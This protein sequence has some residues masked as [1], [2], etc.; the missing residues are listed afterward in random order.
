M[1]RHD[2]QSPPHTATTTGDTNLGIFDGEVEHA[3]VNRALCVAQKTILFGEQTRLPF[4]PI[5]RRLH[6]LHAG[7]DRVLLLWKV[8]KKIPEQVR[9][10]LIFGP[11]SITLAATDSL[12]CFRD[13]RHHQAVHIGRRR[14]TIYLP[15]LLLFQAEEKGYDYWALAEGIIYAGWMLLDY[16]LLADVLKRFGE[17][18]DGKPSMRLSEPYVRLFARECNKHRRDHPADAKSE[19]FEFIAGYKSRLARIEGLNVL[20]D[21][22]YVVARQ[23]FDDELEQRWAQLKMERIAD[24]FDYPKMFLF[25]RDIIHGAA[26]EVAQRK[27]QDMKARSFADLL[28]DYRDALRFDRTP[29]LT[30]FCKGIVPKPRAIFLRS[31]VALGVRGPRGFFAAYEEG[32]TEVLDLIHPLWMYLCSLSS[33]PAGVWARVGRCRALARAGRLEGIE[34]ALA[35][36]YVRLDRAPRYRDMVAE[37]LDLGEAGRDELQQVIGLHRLRD[38]DEWATFRM[39][40]QL[41]VTTACDLLDKMEAADS[42][43][44]R[45]LAERRKLHED[46][47]IKHLVSDN[48]HRLTSDPS[49]VLMYVRAYK[50]SLAEFGPADPDTN[51]LLASILIRMDLA[52]QYQQFLSHFAELGPPAISALY[53]VLEQISER[54][55]RRRTILEQA[56]SMLGRILLDRQLRKRARQKALA[57]QAPQNASAEPERAF[58]ETEFISLRRELGRE[59]GNAFDWETYQTTHTT[60]LEEADA[61]GAGSD[62]KGDLPREET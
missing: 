25:D 54:D 16:L 1:S 55:E 48:P 8:L 7:D 11:V 19:I 52:E 49:G 45:L 15:E 24:L 12:L 20:S 2:T 38:A 21:E 41:I 14:K 32:V 62:G 13:Y 31:L 44:T 36:I 61:A 40:K 30:T 58:A 33:D 18:A 59:G 57:A 56:R 17:Y 39:K 43:T 51:A 4:F 22:P 10:P 34:R 26:R 28:H 5:D 47:T 23:V 50:R 60:Q 27:G 37:L 9:N 29:L 3:E 53:D 6:K 35:G 42:G 46:E